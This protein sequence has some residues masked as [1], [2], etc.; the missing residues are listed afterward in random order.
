MP[1]A[2]FRIEKVKNYLGDFYSLSQV[3]HEV[4]RG[5]GG[6][7]CCQLLFGVLPTRFPPSSL[8][9]DVEYFPFIPSLRKGMHPETLGELIVGVMEGLSLCYIWENL[10]HLMLQNRNECIVFANSQVSK[11]KGYEDTSH[12][13]QERGPVW[14]DL[15]CSHIEQPRGCSDDSSQY[16]DVEV[17]TR[18]QKK[19]W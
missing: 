10:S 6:R 18:F 11:S 4:V 9:G 12:W 2:K 7:I 14:H 5:L 16:V 15:R 17:N 8:V 3:R 13:L 19:V 1:C